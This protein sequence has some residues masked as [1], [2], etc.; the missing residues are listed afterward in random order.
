MIINDVKKRAILKLV[1]MATEGSFPFPQD[2]QD[3]GECG[4]GLGW[5]WLPFSFRR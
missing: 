2:R 1:P 5:L 4:V 3:T